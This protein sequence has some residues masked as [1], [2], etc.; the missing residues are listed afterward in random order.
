MRVLATLVRGKLHQSACTRVNPEV[1]S[2]QGAPTRR[3]GV[4]A[5]PAVTTHAARIYTAYS[6]CKPLFVPSSTFT[7]FA[8]TTA[9]HRRSQATVA[10]AWK[11]GT[12]DTTAAPTPLHTCVKYILYYLSSVYICSCSMLADVFSDRGWLAYEGGMKS[13]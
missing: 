11:G 13:S 7:P 9:G 3:P 8:C 10:D 4:N 1:L 6:Y 12:L 5:C 2:H